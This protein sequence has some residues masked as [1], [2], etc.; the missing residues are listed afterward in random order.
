M[1]RIK[2]YLVTVQHGNGTTVNPDRSQQ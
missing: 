2:Q 1:I